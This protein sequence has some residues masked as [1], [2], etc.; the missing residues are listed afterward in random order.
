M[1]PTLVGRI[2]TR[3]FLVLS[4]GLGYTLLV[5]PFLFKPTVAGMTMTTR[6]VYKVTVAGALVVLVAGIAWELVYHALQQLRWDK[7]WPSLFM[8]L[9]GVNEGVTAWFGLHLINRL[10]SDQGV[11]GTLGVDNPIFKLF[12]FHF[13][14]TWILVWLF[15]QG[16]MRVVFL[17]WR[18]EGQKLA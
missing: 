14:T 10:W 9:N 8:L 13:T 3:I 4:V 15:L 12:V 11:P 16:P 1:T 5:T 18:F 6:D 2:R 7:D 17:R